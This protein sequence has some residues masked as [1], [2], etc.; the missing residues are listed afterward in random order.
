MVDTPKRGL[1]PRVYVPIVIVVGALFL[2]II[3]YLVKIG[4]STGGSVFGTGTGANRQAS[5]SGAATAG[6][7]SVNVQG[8]PPAG[9]RV[10]LQELR[11]RIARSPKDD[12]ALTQLGDLYLAVGK[13]SEAIPYYT[14]ALATNPHNVAAHEG[15]TEARADLKDSP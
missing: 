13:Y 6:P 15:L 2:G 14:R 4:F 7:A 1:P 5:A 9:V 11:D 3:G 10:Q 8:G 12:V